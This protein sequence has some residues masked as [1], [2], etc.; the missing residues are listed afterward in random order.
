MAQRL[1]VFVSSP[2]DV[3]AELLRAALIIDKMAQDYR[4]FFVLESYR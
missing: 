3:L 1:R 2:G 4:R